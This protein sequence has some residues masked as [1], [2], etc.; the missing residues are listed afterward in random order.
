M[1]APIS[2]RLDRLAGHEGLLQPSCRSAVVGFLMIRHHSHRLGGDHETVGRPAVRQ[3]PTMRRSRET[4]R[5]SA[6][7]IVLVG[8]AC[9]N[10]MSCWR[11]GAGFR[12]GVGEAVTM[13]D[14]LTQ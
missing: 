5:C 10:T 8:E 13:I 2:G 14:V 6:V 4:A 12:G 7:L 9:A 11:S 3:V 1:T